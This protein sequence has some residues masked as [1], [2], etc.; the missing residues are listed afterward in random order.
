MAGCNV[1]SPIDGHSAM[2]QIRV[3]IK[4]KEYDIL[5]RSDRLQ[6][7]GG[8]IRKL[9]IGD[10]AFIITNPLLQKKFG[11]LIKKALAG[12]GLKTYFLTVPDSEKSKSYQ[13]CIGLIKKISRLQN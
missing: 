12:H 4:N 8:L 11:G 9:D 10:E 7:M 1:Y 13:C 5:I 6:R 2:K 3:N